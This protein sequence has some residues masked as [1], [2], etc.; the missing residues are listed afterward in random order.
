MKINQRFNKYVFI[1]FSIFAISINGVAQSSFITTWDTSNAGTSGNTKITIPA[2]GT[3]DA[4]WDNDGVFDEKDITGT[5]T[6][7]FAASGT[8]TIALRS[9]A[10]GLGTLDRIVF[11]YGGDKLKLLKINQWGDSSWTSMEDA[12]W[13]C[14]NLNVVAD[15][16]PDLSRVTSL[17]NMFVYCSRLVGNDKFNDWNVSNVT[18]MKAMFFDATAFNQ[19]IGSWDVSN[20]TNMKQM[21]H[22]AKVFNQP[23][24]NWNVSN[25]TNMNMMF[26]R[27]KAF[28]QPLGNWDVSNVTSMELMFDRATSFNQDIGSWDLSSLAYGAGMFDNSGMSRDNWDATL[29]GWNAQKFVKS[30]SV[31][32][33]ADGLTYCGAILERNNLINK[34]VFI[35]FGDK[36]DCSGLGVGDFND[37]AATRMYPNPTNGKVH[38]SE[39]VR[40]VRIYTLNGKSVFETTSKD[41]DISSLESG[42]YFI[43][44]KNEKGIETKRLVK[45]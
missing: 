21:F 26:F 5:H 2:I 25:V 33:G 16:T 24:G 30:S 23:I 18:N 11:N 3:Y 40:N 4:D 15:D 19:D 36:K 12:F 42:I 27:A 8:Y 38:V 28:N 31:T 14:E 10:S 9:A 39:E 32:I 29:K 20:V 43:V 7:T 13:G 44:V 41:F 35:F 45:M 6:H 34:G 17:N 22:Y 1:F 37:T